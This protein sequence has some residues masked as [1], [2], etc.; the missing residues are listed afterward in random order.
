MRHLLALT[1]AGICILAAGC[2][3]GSKDGTTP[4]ASTST[5]TAAPAA[6][7]APPA[8]AAPVMSGHYIATETD[9]DGDQKTKD[10]YLTPCGNGCASVASTPGGQAEGRAQLVNGQWTVDNTGSLTCDDGT[11]VADALTVHLTWDPNTLAGTSQETMVA[12]ACG[13]PAGR[14]VTFKVQ[15]RKAP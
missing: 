14:S 9:P 12:P 5:T 4:A 6:T 3:G 15:L 7:T 11:H 2:G 10:W 8:S 1:C 13:T